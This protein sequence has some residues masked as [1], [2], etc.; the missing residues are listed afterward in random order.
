MDIKE[1]SFYVAGY[2]SGLFIIGACSTCA[3]EN[4]KDKYFTHLKQHRDMSIVKTKFMKSFLCMLDSLPLIDSSHMK[5]NS[6]HMQSMSTAG[7]TQPNQNPHNLLRNLNL[8]HSFKSQLLSIRFQDRD[9]IG[10]TTKSSGL[11][12]V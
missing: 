7:F 8:R 9:L 3:Y 11:G 12:S 4:H 5:F 10:I 6:Q 1:S 2:D